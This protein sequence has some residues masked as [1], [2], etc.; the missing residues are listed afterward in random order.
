MK[1]A[2]KLVIAKRNANLSEKLGDFVAE[3]VSLFITTK[4]AKKILM[5]IRNVYGVARTFHT[6]KHY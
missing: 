5:D 1:F 4:S 2:E 6:E 3:D